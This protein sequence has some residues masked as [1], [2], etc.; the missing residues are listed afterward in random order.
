MMKMQS[1]SIVRNSFLLKSEGLNLR[2][3]TAV[4]TTGSPPYPS[5]QIHHAGGGYE[6]IYTHMIEELAKRGFAGVSMIHRGYPGSDGFQEYGQGE[7]A[8]IGNLVRELNTDLRIDSDRMGIMGY[9]RGAH[10]ALLAIE[11]Y[12]YFRA[13]ALWSAPVDMV[14]H[15]RVNPW[16][17]EIIGGTAEE[18]P[19]LYHRLSSIHFVDRI[20]CP[21]LLIHGQEDE[22]IPLR[23]ALRLSEAL[24]ALGKPCE[25]KCHPNEGHV[26]SPHIFY[27]N[28]RLTLDF[29]ERKL[30]PT[31]L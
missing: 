5:V 29:F 25:I 28:W 12:D 4:P 26:W 1:D 20:N 21:V 10:N 9:S 8:D 16:I 11:R 2:V 24:E 27:E 14:D 22:V 19:E 18:L 23:H 17:A 7:V 13:A 3:F 15:V 31:G 6:A 30:I